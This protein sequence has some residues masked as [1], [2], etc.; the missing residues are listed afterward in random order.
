[1]GHEEG[2]ESPRQFW[3]EPSRVSGSSFQR[4]DEH[5]FVSL[6]IIGTSPSYL[7]HLPQRI[8]P[9]PS[10]PQKKAVPG[11]WWAWRHSS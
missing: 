11:A 7:S 10:L 1:M 6:C 8:N 3:K 2:E 9:N 5:L 4:G